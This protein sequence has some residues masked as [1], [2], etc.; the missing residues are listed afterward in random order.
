MDKYSLF[1]RRKEIKKEGHR[2]WR[3]H[4]VVLAFLTLI[5][6]L[7]G[8][9][10]TYS[11]QLIGQKSESGTSVTIEFDG[12][13]TILDA[14]D[15][16]NNIL[17]GNLQYG[18]QEAKVL[19][20]E[21][22]SEET[23]PALGRTRGVLAQV[24]NSV[25]S[26][27]LP[28]ML[29]QAVYAVV[30]SD[31]AVAAV[32]ILGFA[33]IY[34]LFYIF[35]K[36]IYSV[37]LRRVYLEARVYEKVSFRDIMQIPAMRKWIKAAWTM[38]VTDVIRFLWCLTIVGVVRA[39]AY[40]PVANIIAENP[41]ITS[42]EARMLSRKMMDGHKMDYF[43]FQLSFVGWYILEFLT[44]GI[45]DM[46]YGAGYRLA[47]DEEFYARIREKAINNAIEET[48]L[49]GND[50]YLFRKADKIHLYETYF[51]VVDE[52]TLIHENRITLSG[53][54]KKFADWFSIWIGSM[55]D[56]KQY[57]D[58]E[59]REF[60]IQHYKLCMAGECY[61][62]W[63]N[64]MWRKR[65]IEKMGNFSFLRNYSVW[66]L[67]LLF[68]VFSFIGWSWEVALHY[69]QTGEFANRG[70]LHGPWLP[71]YGSG[72]AIVLIICS[73][74]RKN[75]VA[76][77]ITAIILC[78]TLEY[79][80]AWYLE[81]AYHQRWWSYDGYFL[82]LHGRICAE[83]LLVFGVG[84]CVVVYFIA[85]FFDFLVSKIKT[86]ILISIC[87]V[88]ATLFL[89]DFIYS[90][91]HPNTAKGAVEETGMLD[92]RPDEAKIGVSA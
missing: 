65:E 75:P 88:L 32:F 80:S 72:G 8:T 92:L 68:I 21:R 87:V 45:S 34:T 58:Q 49:I 76:E 41:D 1:A 86:K 9:E 28:A 36:K 47:C 11:R 90:G 42:K 40:A 27:K 64:P 30:K 6:I 69:M 50:P 66:T 29:G 60:S 33:I 67:I 35:V 82:N 73:R 53:I 63:L 7:F 78:G 48:A 31:K 4:Y 52:I 26:G 84:C 12:P 2:V 56:K 71:I 91:S 22:L 81:T 24:V 13:A 19:E 43:L 57:D 61:P 25:T 23:N 83:G 51:D 38:F 70:T 62:E 85:P 59:A 37:A 5:M 18:V 10:Y 79:F 15:V 39:I 46:I 14:D 89:A 3:S 77:F 20:E 74:F 55:K 54:K 44:F 17:N 16:L